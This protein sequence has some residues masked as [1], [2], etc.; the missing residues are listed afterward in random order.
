METRSRGRGNFTR[1]PGSRP[2]RAATYWRG[3]IGREARVALAVMALQDAVAA[4]I[5]QHAAEA[6]LI[7][8]LVLAER[9]RRIA[10]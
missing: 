8:R 2:G 6:Q 9:D 7:A 10:E 3:S 5:A 1:G 4:G